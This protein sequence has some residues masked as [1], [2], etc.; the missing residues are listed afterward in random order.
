MKIDKARAIKT[1]DSEKTTRKENSKKRENQQQKTNT[2]G[3]PPK[4]ENSSPKA[5]GEFKAENSNLPL[6]NNR[7]EK[8]KTGSPTDWMRIF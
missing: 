1:A 2:T 4:T 7:G 8:I 6:K 5:I 3:F